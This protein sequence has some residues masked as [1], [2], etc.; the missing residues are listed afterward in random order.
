M[1]VHLLGRTKSEEDRQFIRE[2]FRQYERHLPLPLESS[3]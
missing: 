3:H 1:K 2:F